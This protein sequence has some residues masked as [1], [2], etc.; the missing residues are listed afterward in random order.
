M[1]DPTLRTVSASQAAALFDQ[2]PYCTRWMLWQHFARGLPLGAEPDERIEW[3]TLLQ[4]DILRAT[5]RRYRFEVEEN[6][7]SIY[8]RRG[9]L[10]ATID[11]RM[12]VPD[13]GDVIIEAKN[14][15]WQRWRDTWSES[16]AAPH[17]EIQMQV[18]LFSATADRGVI[19]ALVGGNELKCYER[20]TNRALQRELQD[21]AGDFLAS[22]VAG[23]E[24]DPLGSPIEL[25]LLAALYPATEAGAVVE[26]H[27]DEE[28]AL[29]VRQYAWAAE[30]EAFAG[31]L[32][33][34]LRA[35]LLGRLGAAAE[36]HV[37]GGR[38]YAK[39]SPI[40]PLICAPHAE[41]RELRHASVQVRLKPVIID[42][43]VEEMFA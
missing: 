36:L 29:A 43:A 8:L 20:E 23:K 21:A 31:K 16:A 19:A 10:G 12:R 26:A 27:G 3:G 7:E 32:K 17:V 37:D 35:K 14:I 9:P 33:N 24:P 6:S 4:D 22:V 11:G 30:Q 5:A 13:Q 28:L 42:P 38:V 41:P 39:R 15:D 2:S 40:A 18:Q 1:P 34:Q 25:P